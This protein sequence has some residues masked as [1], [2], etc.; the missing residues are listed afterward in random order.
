VLQTRNRHTWENRL[1]LSGTAIDNMGV[2]TN[3]MI[4]F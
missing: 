2:H 4:G 1:Q 3:N